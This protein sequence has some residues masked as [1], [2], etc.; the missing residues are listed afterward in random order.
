MT[1]QDQL[2]SFFVS[3]ATILLREIA[4]WTH[5]KSMLCEITKQYRCYWISFSHNSIFYVCVE[6]L[7]N[8]ISV[9]AKVKE[10]EDMAL[11]IGSALRCQVYDLDDILMRDFTHQG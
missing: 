10:A 3:K 4:H 9:M 8:E 2:D 7:L 1:Y 5:T 11:A 6:I